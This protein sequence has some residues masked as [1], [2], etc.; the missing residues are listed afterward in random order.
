MIKTEFGATLFFIL[1]LKFKFFGAKRS[2]SGC[3]KIITHVLYA[4]YSLLYTIQSTEVIFWAIEFNSR[5]FGAIKWMGQF[6]NI[7]TGTSAIVIF[8]IVIFGIKQRSGIP[9]QG[10]K[11]LMKSSQIRYLQ[12]HN[13]VDTHRKLEYILKHRWRG[14]QISAQVFLPSKLTEA[15]TILLSL[16]SVKQERRLI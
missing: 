5:I 6:R 4:D 12:R 9:I 15:Y 13:F 7:L 16:Q 11:N 10:I 2:F 8:F 3:W 1:V 14:N